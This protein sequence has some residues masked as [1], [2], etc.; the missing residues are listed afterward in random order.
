[1]TASPIESRI[2]INAAPQAIHAVWLRVPEWSAWDPDTRDARL[3]GPVAVGVQ[4][5]LTPRKGRRVRMEVVALEPGRQLRVRC[6]V[7][8]SA[9]HFDHRVSPDPAGGSQVVH[10][11]WF[12][13]WLAPVLRA[14]VGR[15]VREGLPRTL[16]SLKRFVEAGC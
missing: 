9:M 11:V 15:D 5:W 6:P 12:T 3:D 4:G 10:A 2:R 7:L 13:G 1:M 14:T 16:A 8:G